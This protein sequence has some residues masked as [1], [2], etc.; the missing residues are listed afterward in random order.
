M[1]WLNIP[2][3]V[4]RSPEFVGAEPT[5]RA[6]WFSLISYCAEQENG[7]VIAGCREW[8]CR[9]WQQTAAVTAPEISDV[10]ELFWFDAVGDLHVAFYPHSA[11]NQVKAGR[12]GGKDGGRPPKN[13]PPK[14]EKPSPKPSP[15]PP[16]KPKDKIREGKEREEREKKPPVA[17]GALAADLM[18]FVNCLR[19]EW[20]EVPGWTADEQAAAE[21]N[22]ACL[23]SI[24]L[25]T[26]ENMR[27]WLL[28]RKREGDGRWQPRSRLKF[29]EAPG[30]LASV[31]NSW[32]K[33]TPPKVPKL[34]VVPPP[35]PAE[36]PTEE[37]RKELLKKI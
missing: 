29:L 12:A 26:W 34:V 14:D 25:S 15:K 16:A 36:V 23:E 35:D 37:E 9:R 19:D 28:V 32:A 18:D 7:G 33:A 3:S 2:V 8:V 30:D 20:A 27:R 21:R 4:A 5:Q 31:A 1:N 24:G 10:C 11:E 6:T 13:P 17:A 22:R